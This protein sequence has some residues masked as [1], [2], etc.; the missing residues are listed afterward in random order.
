MRCEA[1]GESR[2]HKIETLWSTFLTK[3]TSRKTLIKWEVLEKLCRSKGTLPTS[4]ERRSESVHSAFISWFG[5]LNAPGEDWPFSRFYWAESTLERSARL[6]KWRICSTDSVESFIGTREDDRLS[7]ADCCRFKGEN[8]FKS[9]FGF[10][11]IGASFWASFFAKKPFSADHYPI[12]K[13][14]SDSIRIDFWMTPVRGVLISF[15]RTSSRRSAEFAGAEL[16]PNRIRIVAGS[17]WYQVDTHVGSHFRIQIFELN[18]SGSI[19]WP[20]GTRLIRF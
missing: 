14:Y 4:A 13:L 16:Y 5:Q 7:S 11:S 19:V 3:E 17:W 10:S 9:D 20:V 6:R 15:V 18:L 2:V 8:E 12:N 1:F